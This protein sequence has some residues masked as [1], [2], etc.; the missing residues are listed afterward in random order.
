MVSNHVSNPQLGTGWQRC[1]QTFANLIYRSA[2]LD[3]NLLYST[4]SFCFTK[5]RYTTIARANYT[6][7]QYCLDMLILLREESTGEINYGKSLQMK[8]HTRLDFSG[9]RHKVQTE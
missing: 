8:Y 2:L 5:L 6:V 7:G 1:K 3:T 9:E 4:D